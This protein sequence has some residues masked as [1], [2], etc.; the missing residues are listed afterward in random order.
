MLCD[1]S[2]RFNHLKLL[3]PL[4]FVVCECTVPNRVRAT[5]TPQLLGTHQYNHLILSAEFSTEV[6][7]V[8]SRMVSIVKF[9]LIAMSLVIAL[10][11]VAPHSVPRGCAC[12]ERRHGAFVPHQ[13]PVNYRIGRPHIYSAT[14]ISDHLRQRRQPELVSFI[15]QRFLTPSD[16]IMSKS[17]DNN[18]ASERAQ[19]LRERAK[20]LRLEAISA[21]QTLRNSLQ[22]KKDAKNREADRYIDI[23]LGAIAGKERDM[24][25]TSTHSMPTARTLAFR[26]RENS[27]GIDK[28]INIVERLHDRETFM[29]IGPEG[30]LSRQETAEGGGFV[31]GDYENNSLEYKK[32]EIERLS[33]L[34]DR[35]LEA[36][37]ILDQEK[38]STDQAENV[39]SSDWGSRLRVR[40][41]D[42]RKRRD[43][44]VERRVNVLV[45]SAKTVRPKSDKSF[46]GYVKISIASEGESPDEIKQG[47]LSGEKMMKRLIETPPWLPPSLAAFAAT[48]SVEISPAHWK[49]IKS[50]LLADSGFDCASWD[51]T[52][53]AAVFRGR[54]P[55][56]AKDEQSEKHSIE[57]IFVD[58][59]MKLENHTKLNDLIQL[60]LVD[61]NE[62]LPPYGRGGHDNMK[63][64]G[65]GS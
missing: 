3:S 5:D 31:L 51:S 47:K 50:D 54:V 6:G 17:N 39:I 7:N 62:W 22:Q 36:A 1:T 2:R 59:Q 57:S 24:S 53:V 46:E 9:C 30:Y 27:L 14:S 38:K 48:C 34:L 20:A 25:T 8:L 65:W 58:L 29:T 60:F 64:S 52:E 33:G 16:I 41:A 40:V 26:I 11:S 63:A 10:D 13:T 37:A 55:R 28:L 43:A 42:L 56:A 44:L 19:Q 12:C 18:N 4:F 23:L 15:S 45:N 35:I 21:E 49:L 61:D 32:E